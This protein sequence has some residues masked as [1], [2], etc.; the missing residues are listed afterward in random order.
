MKQFR[1]ID[2]LDSS[3]S[4]NGSEDITLHK[5]FIDCEED[6]HAIEESYL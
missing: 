1:I 4:A 2:R 6:L 5:V 3:N